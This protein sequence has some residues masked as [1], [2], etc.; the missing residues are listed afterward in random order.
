MFLKSRCHFLALWLVEHVSHSMRRSLQST[1]GIAFRATSWTRNLSSRGLR[2]LKFVMHSHPLMGGRPP[3]FH[4]KIDEKNVSYFLCL[5]SPTHF[6]AYNSCSTCT[7]GLKFVMRIDRPHA[8]STITFCFK[9]WR[10]L[11]I[12]STFSKKKT[13]LGDFALLRLITSVL[14]DLGVWNALCVFIPSRGTESH[15]L[16]WKFDENCSVFSTFSKMFLK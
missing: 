7:K 11:I 1:A 10:K 13:F 2:W 9:I 15:I 8:G 14:M 16:N 12:F 5:I 6:P 3:K 4:K